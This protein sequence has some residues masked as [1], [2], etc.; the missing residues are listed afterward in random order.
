MSRTT[1]LSATAVPPEKGR[2]AA[3][4]APAR[5]ALRPG[6]E[7]HRSE[8]HQSDWHQALGSASTTLNAGWILGSTRCIPTGVEEELAALYCAYSLR[9]DQIV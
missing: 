1:D 9:A 5:A 7:W 6:R 4:G 2:L 3:H 8:G